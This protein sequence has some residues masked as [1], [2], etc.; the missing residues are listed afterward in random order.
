[1]PAPAAVVAEAVPSG[2]AEEDFR[3]A[4]AVV[5]AVVAAAALVAV[6]AVVAVVAAAVAG[7]PTSR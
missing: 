5:S 3:E 4:V 6:V 7:A 1:L 2:P